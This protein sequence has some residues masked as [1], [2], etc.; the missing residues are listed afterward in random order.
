MIPTIKSIKKQKKAAPI[1]FFP[2]PFET[3][4]CSQ[5]ILYYPTLSEYLLT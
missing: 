5:Y 4:L 3:G 2:L 1:H